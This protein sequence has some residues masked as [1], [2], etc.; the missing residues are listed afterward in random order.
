MEN[1]TWVDKISN[2]KVLQ[3]LNETKTMLDTVGKCKRVV[4]A[5]A[6]TWIT[7]AWYN[8]GKNEGEGYKR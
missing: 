4:R 8:R 1:I 3:R 7:T 5:Y 2:E 6:K